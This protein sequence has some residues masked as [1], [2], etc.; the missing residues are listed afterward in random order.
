[1]PNKELID[2]QL[3]TQ[4]HQKISE[5]TLTMS[6][7]EFIWLD[8]GGGMVFKIDLNELYIERDMIKLHNN[9]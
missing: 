2:S 1:M 3:M 5:L 8:N 6:D 9:E 4:L 7:N